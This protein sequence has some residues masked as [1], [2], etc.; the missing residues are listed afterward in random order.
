MNQ[1]I[2]EIDG[3]RVYDFPV[4]YKES[5]YDEA[6]A[7]IINQV[8][9]TPGL[10][11]LFEY[12]WIPYP[13]I[14]DMDFWAVFSDDVEKMG[15]PL[16]PAL[17]EK[18]KYLMSH[19]ITLFAEKHYRKMLYFDPWT[20]YIWPNG[21]RLLYKK[22]SVERDVNFENIKFT[23]DERNVL[24]LA[25]VE[26]D[27]AAINPAISLYA[28]K[29]LPARHILEVIKTCVYI[30]EEINLIADRKI[31]STFPEELQN[32][33]ASWF[34][35][36][37]RQ[38]ARRLIKLFYDGLLISF[39]AAFSLGDWVR[40][41]SESGHIQ[42]LGIKKT[43]FF[44]GSFLDKKSKNIYLNSFG[45]R[46]V[47]TDFVRNPSQALELSIN[48]C[49]KFEIKLG[50]YSKIIDFY[51]VFQPLEL[52]AIYLGLISEKGLLSDNLRKNTF[53]NLE[54]L[55]I[56]RPQIFREKIKMLNEITEVYNNKRAAGAGGK[57]WHFGNSS[58]QNSFEH[59]KL[60]KKLLV[61]WL[62]RKFWRE[63][64]MAVKK[65]ES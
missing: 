44:N 42:D 52:A 65:L 36:D 6:R 4:E 61:F 23:K 40:Q 38:A 33:R 20:T 58:F 57:G 24:S 30:I 64:N 15:L 9:N 45:D 12:G 21:Q 11:A 19:Q 22:E 46:R 14:S 63:I 48:S 27:L 56:F 50:R 34:K 55:L 26:E 54:E 51:V 32:L 41:R 8:R 1:K 25:R 10:V 29:E 16:R 35:L 59:K 28:K 49:R 60:K 2:M 39:E 43:N 62:K 53:S 3:W 5:D 13:G 18:T 17:S 37:R 7:E 31:N 47:F